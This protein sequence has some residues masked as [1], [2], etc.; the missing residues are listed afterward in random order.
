MGLGLAGEEGQIFTIKKCVTMLLECGKKLIYRSSPLELA[1]Q[2]HHSH[3]HGSG[4]QA[5]EAFHLTIGPFYSSCL[6]TRTIFTDLF[7]VG[8]TINSSLVFT[9]LYTLSTWKP[10]PKKQLSSKHCYISFRKQ[11]ERQKWLSLEFSQ[12]TLPSVCFG[13]LQLSGKPSAINHQSYLFQSAAARWHTST[14]WLCRVPACRSSSC[15][16]SLGPSY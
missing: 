1:S 6:E 11:W 10:F 3:S 9:S 15:G 8:L 12:H 4:L 5:P 16:V 13:G 7:L 14:D 2:R